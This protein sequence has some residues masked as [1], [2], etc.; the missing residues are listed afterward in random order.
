MA[1]KKANTTT[2]QPK[3]AP[4]PSTPPLTPES[5]LSYLGLGDFR[6]RMPEKEYQRGGVV[7]KGSYTVPQ[8]CKGGKVIRTYK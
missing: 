3:A 8:L 6:S 1:D 5:W 4:P 7:K 2:S